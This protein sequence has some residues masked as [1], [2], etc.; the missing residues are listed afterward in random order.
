VCAHDLGFRAY[1]SELAVAAPWQRC[2]IG[3]ALVAVVTK[4][5]AS[6]GCSA[7]VADIYPPAVAFYERMGWYAPDA[8]PLA[9]KDGRDLGQN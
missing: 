4:E 6:R 3:P 8:V 5:L 1:L 7:L 2:G 9:R